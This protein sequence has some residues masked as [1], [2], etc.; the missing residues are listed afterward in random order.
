[1]A[2]SDSWRRGQNRKPLAARLSL[3]PLEVRIG[4]LNLV[5]DFDPAVHEYVANTTNA[6]NGVTVVAPDGVEVSISVNGA[7]HSNGDA[8]SWRV[9]RNVV[10]IE[11]TQ[12]DGYSAAYTVYVVKQGALGE[13]TVTSFGAGGV[14]SLDVTPKLT[15]GFSYRYSVGGS[16]PALDDD[17]EGWAVWDG[18]SDIDADVGDTVVLAEVLLLSGLPVVKKAGA[19]VVADA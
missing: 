14:A 6:K 3:I 15:A 1:M 4:A 2:G 9:G 7:M 13:L 19:A 17:V 10:Y 18:V 12:S 5:P 16:L 11:V 8:Y